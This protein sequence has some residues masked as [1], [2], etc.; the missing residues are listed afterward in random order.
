M[1]VVSP[2]PP[3]PPIRVVPPASDGLM[4]EPVP[5]LDCERLPPI[6]SPGPISGGS[7]DSEDASALS[8]W[9]RMDSHSAT[10]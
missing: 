7:V 4:S 2:G 5:E 8:M 3:V 1:K 6:A 10:K 9:N